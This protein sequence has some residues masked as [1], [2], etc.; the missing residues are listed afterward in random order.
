MGDNETIDLQIVYNPVT[1]CILP[2]RFIHCLYNAWTNQFDIHSDSFE[3]I[4]SKLEIVYEWLRQQLSCLIHHNF[5][6]G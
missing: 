6:V 2:L 3:D 1:M 5:Y 4:S